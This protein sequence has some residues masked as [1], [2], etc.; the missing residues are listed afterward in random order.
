MVHRLVFLQP[1]MQQAI[2]EI[3]L[4]WCTVIVMTTAILSANYYRGKRLQHYGMSVHRSLWQT[5]YLCNLKGSFAFSIGNL[6]LLVHEQSLDKI[7]SR[8]RHKKANNQFCIAG[9]QLHA[10]ASFKERRSN[11]R[12]SK[13]LKVFSVTAISCIMKKGGKGMV[14]QLYDFINSGR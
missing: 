10:V 6:H 14:G 4:L 2:C 9:L 3:I 12:E 1:V 13:Q 5:F 8:L 7:F 11:I